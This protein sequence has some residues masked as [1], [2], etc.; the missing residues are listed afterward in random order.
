MGLDLACTYE[1]IAFYLGV[2]D[3]LAL[4]TDGLLEACSPTGEIY[5]F[6]RLK[7]LFA[8]KPSAQEAMDAAI[9]FGQD[10]DIT[11]LTLARLAVGEESTALSIT[12]MPIVS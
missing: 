12:P 4:Y 9:D 7:A 2:G 6:D 1:E 11:V 5:G 3:R 8:T 10:D